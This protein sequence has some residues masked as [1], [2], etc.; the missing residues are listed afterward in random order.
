MLTP[1]KEILSASITKQNR[2][3]EHMTQANRYKELAVLTK[4][5]DNLDPAYHAAFYLMTQS[6]TKPPADL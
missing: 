2:S 3:I 5:V 1:S 4:R 6:F